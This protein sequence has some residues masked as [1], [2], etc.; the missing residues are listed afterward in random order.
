MQAFP[1]FALSGE[2]GKLQLL[3]KADIK[4]QQFRTYENLQI[5]F[6][7]SELF[8][9]LFIHF[10]GPKNKKSPFYFLHCKWNTL[11]Q[12]YC[13]NFNYSRIHLFNTRWTRAE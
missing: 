7:S 9:V 4:Y 11:N 6:E 10:Y 13:Q 8:Y 5:G 3:Q 12:A 2:F 1:N